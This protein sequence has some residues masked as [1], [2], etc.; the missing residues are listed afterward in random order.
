MVEFEFRLL[1]SD[2]L[3]HNVNSMCV[4]IKLIRNFLCY[5]FDLIVFSYVVRSELI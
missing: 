4:F 5:L 1:S 3:G 2:V